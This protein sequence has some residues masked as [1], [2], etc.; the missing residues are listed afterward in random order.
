M[1]IGIPGMPQTEL[2]LLEHERKM[3]HLGALSNEHNNILISQDISN[4]RLRRLHHQK[5][6]EHMTGIENAERRQME[7]K[8]A[9]ERQEYERTKLKLDQ[10]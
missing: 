3:E 2:D 6:L 10:L 4:Y 9:K 5:Q 1:P 7:E 8:L